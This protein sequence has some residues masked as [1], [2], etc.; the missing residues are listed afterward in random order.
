MPRISRSKKSTK[1][2]TWT[3]WVFLSEM[4]SARPRALASIARVAMNGTTPP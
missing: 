2:G 4:I 3:I 1:P